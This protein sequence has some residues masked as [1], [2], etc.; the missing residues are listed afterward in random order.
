VENVEKYQVDVSRLCFV[1]FEK[2]IFSVK[3][4]TICLF[5][6]V[7]L[8]SPLRFFDAIFFFKVLRSINDEN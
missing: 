6:K 1:R 4:Q 8:C 7:E 2:K 3:N 5:Y